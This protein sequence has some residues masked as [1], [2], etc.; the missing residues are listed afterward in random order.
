MFRALYKPDLSCSLCL[1]KTQKETELHLLNCEYFLQYPELH[2]EMKNIEYAD[3][4]KD[5]SKQT[6][7]VRVWIKV[8]KLYNKE[9]EKRK[10]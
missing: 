3:I 2:A 1:D 6:K 7:A 10:Q 8:F 5:M 9:K 4:F